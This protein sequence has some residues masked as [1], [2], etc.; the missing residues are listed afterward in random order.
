[1]A[2]Q[3]E[4]CATALAASPVP[5]SRPVTREQPGAA[6]LRRPGRRH[7][8]R[9]R[10]DGCHGGRSGHPA[11]ERRVAKVRHGIRSGAGRP[12]VGGR[13]GAGGGEPRRLRR[14]R[15]T[16]AT[17]VAAEAATAAAHQHLGASGPAPVSPGRA[18]APTTN[19]RDQA[20]DAHGQAGDAC[21][22][23]RSRRPGWC[24]RARGAGAATAPRPPWHRRRPGWPARSGR[25]PGMPQ[26]SPGPGRTA[27]GRR[28][29][30]RHPVGGVHRHWE[31]EN[32]HGCRGRRH[33]P[34]T[35]RG[36]VTTHVRSSHESTAR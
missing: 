15:T 22:R 1:M 6:R 20:A 28:R 29:D 5:R 32:R 13:E 12:R 16:S 33:R 31:E 9:G 24:P 2:S 34:G 21:R 23:A 26:A 4:A 30:A 10:G 19:G 27:R 18:G 36:T 14:R 17:V 7:R 11:A 3:P 8:E 25:V 35:L